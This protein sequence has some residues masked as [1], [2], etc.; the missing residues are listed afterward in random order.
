MLRSDAR[1]AATTTST[2]TTTTTPTTTT[3]YVN[4][5]S[6]AAIVA[7]DVANRVRAPEYMLAT[8]TRGEACNFSMQI[9][10]VVRRESRIIAQ[11]EF[12]N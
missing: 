7:R 12:Y 1:S 6:S 11:S 9:S 3:T 4:P 10:L 8:F 2:T 5:P